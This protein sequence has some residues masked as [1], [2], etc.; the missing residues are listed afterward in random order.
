MPAPND[1]TP[2]EEQAFVEHGV[3]PA[4]PGGEPIAEGQEEAPPEGQEPAPVEGQETSPAPVE[5]SRHREDGTFKSKEEYEA[6]VAA[7]QAAAAQPQQQPQMVPH[8]ALH[9]ARARAAENARIAQL[10]TA[11]LNAILTSQR[12][13]G[14][15]NLEQMPDI[16]ENPAEYILALERRLSQFEQ[17]R[18]EETK[19]REIDTALD[20]DESLFSQAVPDYDQASDYFVQSRARELLQFYPPD[21]TQRIMTQEARQIAQQAWQRG[22]SAAAVVYQL[23][24]A[25]GYTPGNTAANPLRNPTPARPAVP[26]TPVGG[27]TPQAVIASVNA[28]QQASRSLSGGAGGQGTEQMNAEALLNMNDDEFEAYLQL[29]KKG[30]D[31]RF[32]AIG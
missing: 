32:A 21:E 15:P 19:F 11:R 23:A 20:N 29:G 27:P 10:A 28:G 16:A 8:Q 26:A 9:E 3:Q 4:G 22:Q 6:E 5:V 7:A 2:E 24:Q 14:Q 25:R 12:Q 17:A 1:L 13:Q 31:A 18:Q 30:A